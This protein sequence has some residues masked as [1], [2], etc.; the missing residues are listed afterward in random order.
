MTQRTTR[1]KWILAALPALGTLFIGWTFFLSPANHVIETMR[2]R[3]EKQGPVS[4]RLMQVA[5]VK[6][7]CDILAKAAAGKRAAAAEQ[8]MRFDRN[9]AMQQ[10]SLLCAQQGLSL[11][12]TAADTGGKL[13]PPLQDAAAA[14]LAGEGATAPQLWRL[15]LSGPYGS[16]VKLLEGLREAQPLIVPLN[17]SMETGKKERQPAKWVLTLWL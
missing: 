10:I 13:P 15:E 3:V 9:H 8:G 2:A 16:V 17:L 11:N 7:D 4:A 5:R 6:E 12:T 1:E 14:T